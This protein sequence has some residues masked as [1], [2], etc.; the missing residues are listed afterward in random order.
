MSN[1]LFPRT[2]LALG[3]ACC[4]T[5]GVAP[6]CSS[7]DDEDSGGEG[8]A[9]FNVYGEDYI[10]Q[11]IPTSEFEDGW[12]ITYSKFLIQVGNVTLADSNKSGGATEGAVT[13]F[14]LKQPGPQE[15]WQ[16]DKIRSGGYDSVSYTVGPVSAPIKS[17]SV[18]D[19]DV[20]FMTS[21][22]YGV[23]VEGSASNGTDTK[24]FKWGFT[25]TTHY[26]S[27]VQV[28]DAG[29]EVREGILVANG[30]IEQ[31]QLTIHGDHLFYDDLTAENA[32]LRFNAMAAAD[33]NADGDVTREELAAVQLFD[34]TEGSYGTGSASGVNTLDDFVEALTTT[35]GHFRGEGH[36]VS[37]SE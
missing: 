24:T 31:V 9:S 20:T 19:A 25:N 35:L 10:E 37:H 29:N 18:T 15:L 30:G 11:E 22:G 3:L 1:H 36:C 6:G 2:P 34:L 12:T 28:D 8:Q 4:L 7:S 14:D 32:V 21:N 33:A 5:L 23:Y 26:K 13:L 16:T 17:N 27:C